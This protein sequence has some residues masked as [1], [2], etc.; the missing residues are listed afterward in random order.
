[1]KI[2]KKIGFSL[3]LLISLSYL[4]II[5][6]PKIFKNFYP[7]GI[8]TAIVL[9][10]SMEPT[11]EVNDF[12]I[13]KKPREIKVNNIIAYKHNGNGEV[14]HRVIRIQDDEIITKGDANNAEDQAINIREVTGVYVGKIKY[15]GKVLSFIRRPIV[16]S[17]IITLLSIIVI[18]S[19]E[20]KS[21]EKELTITSEKLTDNEASK[22]L[23]KKAK[24]PSKVN[25][26]KQNQQKVDNKKT[27]IK[28]TSNKS[29]AYTKKY[30][31]KKQD[32][33]KNKKVKSNTK[34]NI[35]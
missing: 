14:L 33:P 31:A 34:K 12:V 11:L 19:R 3:F 4:F 24:N 32:V 16:F 27:V 21:D 30:K 29:N 2:M 26:S 28:K 15:L 25:K 23:K 35:K 22:E 13:I 20:E 17:T 1:M 8:K 9:T 18:V 7:F 5:I 6:S 10:G